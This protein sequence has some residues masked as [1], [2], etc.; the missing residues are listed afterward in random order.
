[1]VELAP[2]ICAGFK[3]GT[4]EAHRLVNET[5]EDWKWPAAR[6]ATS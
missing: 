1:M 3:A 6:Q 2:G 4:G 5:S